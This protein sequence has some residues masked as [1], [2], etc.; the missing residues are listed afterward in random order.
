MGHPLTQPYPLTFEC[1]NF[2]HPETPRTLFYADNSLDL[3]LS[4]WWVKPENLV[5]KGIEG[6]LSITCC[7]LTTLHLAPPITSKLF[8]VHCQI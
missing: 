6:P 1:S 8:H 5:K 4:Y 7:G 2:S 3:Y